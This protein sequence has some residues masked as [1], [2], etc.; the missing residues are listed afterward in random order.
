MAPSRAL[1]LLVVLAGCVTGSVGARGPAEMTAALRTPTGDTSTLAALASSH[2]ATVL[3]FWSSGCP[4]VRRYQARVD[5]F[6]E[7]YASRDVQVLAVASNA[8]EPYEE[9]LSVVKARGVQVPLLHDE[10]GVV[11]KLVGA[12]STPTVA[13]LD[14]SAAVRFVGWL[15][16]ERE[17]GVEG[18][19]AWLEQAVEG[20]LSGASFSKRTPTWGCTI[21]RSLSSIEPRRCE[22]AH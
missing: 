11:A 20:V 12:R 19:E 7:R 21:T 16:N 5:G 6:A 17:P 22:A 15:D 14:R 10:G 13:V 1:L 18:R 2:Q 4:C 3:V 9:A 8:G